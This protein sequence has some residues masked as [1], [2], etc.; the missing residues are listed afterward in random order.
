MKM[1]LIGQSVT[2]KKYDHTRGSWREKERASARLLRSET[3]YKATAMSDP[4]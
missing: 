3:V 2:R 4:P 1:F